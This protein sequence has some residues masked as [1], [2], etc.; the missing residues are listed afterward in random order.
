M[1]KV[2]MEI[3]GME[4]EA[5]RDK[6]RAFELYAASVL[7]A[8]LGALITVEQELTDETVEKA[9]LTATQAAGRMLE[10]RNA[11]DSDDAQD[12]PAVGA[13]SGRRTMN[14]SGRPRSLRAAVAQSR[15]RPK[16][17]KRDERDA[18]I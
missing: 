10:V 5:N 8:T 17:G 2:E 7:G 4:F 13:Q 1:D 12:P 16:T 3:Q 18:D 6:L 9:V 15:M 14:G 11:G